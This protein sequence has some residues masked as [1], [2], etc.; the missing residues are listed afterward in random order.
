M[1]GRDWLVGLIAFGALGVSMP[2]H[3][4][5]KIVPQAPVATD[6]D[7]PLGTTWHFTARWG[8]ATIDGKPWETYLV[9]GVKDCTFPNA[10]HSDA[11]MDKATACAIVLCA[12]DDAAGCGIPV[13]CP[14]KVWTAPIGVL[15]WGNPH[16]SNAY[17]G[18]GI[19]PASKCKAPQQ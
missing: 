8:R 9:S 3:A 11:C 10:Q 13:I 1:I 15:G 17:T 19:I 12:K 5:P 7:K 4:W 14:V 18:S 2:S 6:C 16:A